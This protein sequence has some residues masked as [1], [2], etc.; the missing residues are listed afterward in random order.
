MPDKIRILAMTF[1][2]LTQ[3]LKNQFGK[4]RYHAKAI[5]REI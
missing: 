5:M 2:D 3:R 1:D 4:G